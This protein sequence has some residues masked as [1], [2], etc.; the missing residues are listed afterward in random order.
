MPTL[1]AELG[2]RRRSELARRQDV[3]LKLA[4]RPG[5]VRIPAL[6]LA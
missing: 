5:A 3:R 6:A 1:A 4:R 2:G